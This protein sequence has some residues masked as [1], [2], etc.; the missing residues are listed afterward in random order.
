MVWLWIAAALVSAGL[1]ALVVHRAARAAV[2]TAA[3]NPALAVYRRQMAELDELADRGLLEEG[4]RRAVR[5]ETGRRL[6]AAG[7]RAEPPLR[8]ASRGLVL[9]AAAA[10]P[11][12][13]LLAY[14]AIGTPGFP[15]Q[16]F[17]RRLAE[18]R[19]TPDPATLSPPEMAAIL[20]QV[21]KERPSDPEPL[22]NL[23][24]AELAS[25]QPLEAAQ[26]AQ[27]ALVLAPGR[28][29][30]WE[31]LGEADALANNGEIGD[32]AV[33]AFAKAL[34]LDPSSAAARYALARAKIAHG[35]VSGGL[36]DWRAVETSL[37]PDDPRRQTLAQEIA[38]VSAGGHLASAVPPGAGGPVGAPQIQ[39][40]V[41]G[42]AARLKANPDDPTGWVR[43]VRA[44]GVLGET[45]RQ[46]AALAEARRRYGGRT[47]VLSALSAAASPPGT[48][49]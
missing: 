30:L 48:S 11:F 42:L 24:L 6:L 28:A 26:A 36:A 47:E 10:A 1:A 45:D 43:L 8:T 27:R 15:D 44:Y 29:D 35:D 32:D 7:R 20:N 23:A 18:W 12:M 17:A 21:A 5:A 25:G 16:P 41:D 3:E 39:A 19:A 38:Q 37:A 46:A 13:A 33:A 40:M 31:L 49:R 14:V 22:R 9:A 2:A 34:A 4:E